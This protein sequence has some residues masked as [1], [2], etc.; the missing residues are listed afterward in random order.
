MK[1][2]NGIYRIYRF[3]NGIRNFFTDRVKVK[4][5][6]IDAKKDNV[7]T[8]IEILYKGKDLIL[9]TKIKMTYIDDPRVKNSKALKDLIKDLKL[10]K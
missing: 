3:V 1:R 7:G 2:R 8:H 5:L 6:T 4:T 10:L 9:V